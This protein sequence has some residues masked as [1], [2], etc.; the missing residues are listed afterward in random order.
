LRVAAPAS[1]SGSVSAGAAEAFGIGLLAEPGDS[2]RL[3]MFTRLLSSRAHSL[4]FRQAPPRARFPTRSVSA[5]PT[6][7]I[8]GM[9]E[10][11]SRRRSGSR[12]YGKSGDH[13]RVEIYRDVC[14]KKRCNIVADICT[15]SDR[16]V[17]RTQPWERFVTHFVE[18]APVRRV[19]QRAVPS[20]TSS[21]GKS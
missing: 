5:A 16:L 10:P 12:P 19:I 9:G 4:R 17:R 20:L 13:R 3:G 21:A 7:I 14:C 18:P 1:S 8:P 11:R 2:P 6:P 15:S